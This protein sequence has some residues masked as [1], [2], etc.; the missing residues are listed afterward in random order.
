[1]KD[2]RSL[3]KIF[4]NVW[5]PCSKVAGVTKKW[6]PSQYLIQGI[7]LMRC[8]WRYFVQHNLHY[9][10]CWILK[11]LN[12]GPC[13][14]MFHSMKNWN[15]SCIAEYVKILWKITFC[16][17]YPGG[18]TLWCLCRW[19]EFAAG[20]WLLNRFAWALDKTLAHSASLSPMDFPK[21]EMKFD[22]SFRSLLGL[23]LAFSN[24]SKQVLL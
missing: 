14:L 12:Y 11:S 23:F 21:V 7:S 2:L 19:E 3:S 17:W 15:I 6:T 24:P 18:V 8:L 13:Y 16:C 5:Q 1:M 20:T 4:K 9:Y 10:T 22:I